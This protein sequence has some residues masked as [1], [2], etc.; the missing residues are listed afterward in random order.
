MHGNVIYFKPQQPKELSQKGK[1]SVFSSKSAEVFVLFSGPCACTVENQIISK[2]TLHG[3][4]CKRE[5]F[6]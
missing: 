2:V 1:F 3:T 6:R 5:Q 4:I